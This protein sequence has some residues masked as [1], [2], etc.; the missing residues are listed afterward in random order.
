M[1]NKGCSQTADVTVH[2]IK[3]TISVQIN[4]INTSLAGRRRGPAFR[5]SGCGATW[6]RSR[7]MVGSLAVT[8]RF[9]SRE[10]HGVRLL[11]FLKFYS[12][13]LSCTKQAENQKTPKFGRISAQ[14]G[15]NFG[16]NCRISPENGWFG[17]KLSAKATEKLSAKMSAT[18]THQYCTVPGQ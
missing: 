12:H 11:V 8:V 16:R 5:P 9:A 17:R 10:L 2:A 6:R 3:G 18:T 1:W 15:M 4:T 14:N 7:A 13:Q